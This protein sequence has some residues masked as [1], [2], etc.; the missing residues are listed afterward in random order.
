MIIYNIHAVSE[1][2]VK[3]ENN[4]KAIPNTVIYH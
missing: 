1:N 2:D 3:Q 4:H